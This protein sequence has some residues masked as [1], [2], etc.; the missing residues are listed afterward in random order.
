MKNACNGDITY[1][2]HGSFVVLLHCFR[3]K[4]L[5]F[6]FQTP[7]TYTTHNDHLLLP[8]STH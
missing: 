8:P 5:A 3:A 1:L 4:K 2:K 6:D 7:I